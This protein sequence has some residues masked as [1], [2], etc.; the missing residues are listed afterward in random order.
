MQGQ[1]LMVNPAKLITWVTVSE[2]INTQAPL[3]PKQMHLNHQGQSLMVNP[4]KLI[5]LGQLR[6]ALL[7]AD[8]ALDSYD[9][10]V[11]CTHDSACVVDH[12]ARGVLG[13]YR[14]CDH[15]THI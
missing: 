9:D 14:L 13:L 4:A 11:G 1:S 5:T 12:F 3:T 15:I 7:K 8:K 10:E 2:L 6:E